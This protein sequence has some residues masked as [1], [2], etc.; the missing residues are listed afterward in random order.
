MSFIIPRC[1]GLFFPKMSV[2]IHFLKWD[3]ADYL[4]GF[5]F[6]PITKHKD[7]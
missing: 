7:V 1:L 3:V 5:F 4:A 6:S 2:P